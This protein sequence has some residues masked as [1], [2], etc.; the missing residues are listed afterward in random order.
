MESFSFS[1][2]SNR[3]SKQTEWIY[4]KTYQCLCVHL[5]RDETK[6]LKPVPG[7]SQRAHEVVGA[8]WKSPSGSAQSHHNAGGKTRHLLAQHL[9][10]LAVTREVSHGIRY[11]GFQKLGMTYDVGHHFKTYGHCPASWHSSHVKALEV[12]NDI[13]SFDSRLIYKQYPQNHTR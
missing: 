5:W 12:R 4:A 10:C 9:M 8:T 1:M 13:S 2:A 11:F 3:H 7:F 6:V